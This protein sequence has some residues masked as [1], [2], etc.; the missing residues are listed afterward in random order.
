[1][2][3]QPGGPHVC[4]VFVDGVGL[5][6]GGPDNPLDSGWPHMAQIAGGQRWTSDLA[7]VDRADHIVRSI[8]ANLGVDGLPQSGTGQTALFGGFNAPA[9]AGRHYGPHPHSATRERLERESLFARLAPTH[10]LAFANAYPDRFFAYSE[11]TGRWSTT[12]RMCRA[13]GVRLRTQAD[14]MTGDA[15]TADLT[16]AAWRDR[17]GLDVPLLTPREAGSRLHRLARGHD[18]TLLEYYLTDKAGHSRDWARSGAVL[19]DLDGLFAGYLD[20][21][22]PSRDLLIVTSDHGNLEDLSV[23]PHTRNPVPLIAMGNGADAVGTAT[24]LTDVTPMLS[25]LLTRRP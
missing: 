19:S 5:G 13:A 16:G 11:S 20:A 12:T 18:V 2:S 25:G 21:F 8:D 4:F 15:V 14:L 10:R 24:D 17:L 1:V 22:D 7:D 3:H 6:P 9:L 23:K